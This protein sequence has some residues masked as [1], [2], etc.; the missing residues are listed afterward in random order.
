MEF[1]IMDL[2]GE[3]HPSSSKG[4]RYALTVVYMLTGCTFCIPIKNKSAEEI[5]MAWRKSHH[6]SIWCLQKTTDRQWHHI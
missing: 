1:I 3:F 4:N 2:I 6:L 5:V